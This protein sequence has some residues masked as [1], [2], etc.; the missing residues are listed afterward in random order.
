MV[1]MLDKAVTSNKYVMQSGCTIPYIQI[2][3]YMFT[4]YVMRH[5]LPQ[6]MKHLPHRAPASK[7]VSNNG[8]TI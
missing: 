2:Y 3:K 7:R 4:I 5:L 8:E 1:N 6:P